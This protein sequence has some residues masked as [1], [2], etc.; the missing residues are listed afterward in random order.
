MSSE[1]DRRLTIRT[2]RKLLPRRDRWTRRPLSGVIAAACL[3]LPE[4]QKDVSRTPGV[5]S[6]HY[7]SHSLREGGHFDFILWWQMSFSGTEKKD[8]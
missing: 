2:I 3:Q 8:F 1:D 5:I 6:E 7:L 4:L